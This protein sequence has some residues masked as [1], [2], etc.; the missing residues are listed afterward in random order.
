MRT[1]TRKQSILLH[2]KHISEGKEYLQRMVKYLDHFPMNDVEDGH[3]I[4]CVPH[5]EGKECLCQHLLM[6]DKEA[7]SGK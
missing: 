5:K 3:S 4:F 6:S 7:T 2:C 1:T